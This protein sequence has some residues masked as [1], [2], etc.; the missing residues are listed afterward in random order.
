MKR[1]RV[2]K[3]ILGFDIPMHQIQTVHIRQ[4]LDEL[5]KDISYLIVIEIAT[6]LCVNF[7]IE[8]DQIVGNVLED[9]ISGIGVTKAFQ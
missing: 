7:F 3:N 6:I 5:K 4:S 1:F 9:Q 8:G 2:D